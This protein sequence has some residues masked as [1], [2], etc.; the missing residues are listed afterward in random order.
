MK[1]DL[2]R[3]YL[4][5]AFC[6]ALALVSHAQTSPLLDSLLKADLP[7][8]ATV[9]ANPNKY[10]LQVIYSRIDRNKKNEPAFKDFKFNVNKNYF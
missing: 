6:I 4:L 2:L 7:Q 10:K 5:F 3:S 8:F 1:R 9:L